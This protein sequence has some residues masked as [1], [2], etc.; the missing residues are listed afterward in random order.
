MATA[1]SKHPAETDASDSRVTTDHDEIRRWVESKGGKPACVKGTGDRNDPGVLRIDFP[2][3]SGEESLQ[4]M[5][6]DEWFDKFDCAHL[7]L[8]YQDQTADGHPSRFS[9]LIN[10]HGDGSSTKSKKKSASSHG[11][12]SK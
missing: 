5:D 9:K 7:A 11:Q 12:S 10:R 1:S 8:L 6:W 3:Y 4:E 2:G